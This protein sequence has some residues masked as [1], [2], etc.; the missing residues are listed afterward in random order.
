MMNVR[1]QEQDVQLTMA[2]L[3]RIS[4]WYQSHAADPMVELNNHDLV[5]D[6]KL[7]AIRYDMEDRELASRQVRRVV[8]G[9]VHTGP[10]R[11]CV[12]RSTVVRVV[13]PALRQTAVH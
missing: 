7:R 5:L 9:Y 3:L 6:A 4:R 11:R 13:R 10:E 8:A 1:K 2:E 12:A